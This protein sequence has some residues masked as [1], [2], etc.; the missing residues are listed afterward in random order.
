MDPT[1]SQR[2][3]IAD[4]GGRRVLAGQFRLL[5]V[6][7]AEV[8]DPRR[9]GGGP[10]DALANDLAGIR[11]VLRAALLAGGL[12]EAEREELER[13]EREAREL[14]AEATLRHP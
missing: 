14:L 11:F 6:K 1:T 10:D 9:R 13:S 8:E 3:Q 5:E 2:R 7:R 4:E 12:T